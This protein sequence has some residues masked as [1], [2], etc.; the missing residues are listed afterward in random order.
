[1]KKIR[2]I[3]NKITEKDLY[4]LAGIIDGTSSFSIHK[5]ACG[6][7]DEISQ[8]R[9]PMWTAAIKISG[10][11][12]RLCKMINDLLFLGD[13]YIRLE[14]SNP[15]RRP[16]TNSRILKE[17]RLAG[18]ILDE[19][20]PRLM[21]KLKIKKEHVE[22]LIKFRE[23]VSRN[24]DKNPLPIHIEQYRSSLQDRLKYINSQEYKN[25]HWE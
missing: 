14:P 13:S 7:R 21:D 4:Y 25:E 12:P 2:K 24:N 10:S 19:I 18:P 20:L 15:T 3:N 9:T 1:M 11:N 22:I 6:R 8:K 23:S 16:E 5:T 17:I